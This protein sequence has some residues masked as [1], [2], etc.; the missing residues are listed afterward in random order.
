MKR[1]I[2]FTSKKNFEWTSMQEI[3]PFI[4]KAWLNTQSQEHHVELID[5]DDSSI[6]KNAKKVMVADQ[7]VMTCFTVEM[8]LGLSVLRDQLKLDFRIF[9]YVHGSASIGHWPLFNYKLGSTLR[10]SDVFVLTCDG[11]KRLTQLTL[12]DVI[13]LKHPFLN[14]RNSEIKNTEK[15]EELVYIGRISEQK[16]LH[17]LFFGISLIKDY[18]RD[19]KIKLRIFGGE[20][21]LGSPNMAKKSCS[22]QMF[23]EDLSKNVE[24]EDLIIFEGHV[25]RD[26]LD[27][28]LES[29]SILY[30]APSLHS[31][32]NFGMSPYNVLKK[33]GRC[34]LSD[35]GGFSEF[36]NWFGDQ[37]TYLDIHSGEYGPFLSVTNIGD[38]I[39]K[40]LEIST[41]SSDKNFESYYSF[42]SI[43]NILLEEVNK[44]NLDH[45]K[46]EHTLLVGELMKA[47]DYYKSNSSNIRKNN[48]AQIFSGY[49]D[50]KALPF[51]EGY[52][53]TLTALQVYETDRSYKALPWV[54]FTNKYI[55]LK[56]PRIS[57]ITILREKN[58]TRDF[59]VNQLDVDFLL[60][61]REFEK[62]Y[63]LG[64]LY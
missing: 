58:E 52:A 22:Y 36:R 13:T 28:Y 59:K 12:P 33:G 7:V 54:E 14:D 64:Y 26:H 43:S 57:E 20:D 1:T 62:I 10:K 5:I 11:D 31:D 3:I 2:I 8:S 17:S 6:F 39:K 50:S 53:H 32:E 30:I 51:L 37:V 18:L 19:R 42:E 47:R 21:N 27:K 34:L 44:E 25:S 4:E 49:N 35:W 40:G 23:L 61:K 16:N 9:Y 63:S 56:D 38:M 41:S 15:I 60:S 45:S 24:I 29:T 46:M 48:G 55:Y